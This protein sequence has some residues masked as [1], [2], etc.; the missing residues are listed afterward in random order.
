V[1]KAVRFHK[2]GGPENLVLEDVPLREPGAGEVKLSVQAIGLNRAELLYM[3]GFYFEKPSLPSRIGYEGA[4]IVEAV[5]PDVDPSLAGRSMSAIPGF[6]QNRYGLLAEE[7]IVPVEALREYPPNLSPAEAASI[8]MQYLTAWGALV[9]YAKVGRG[10]FVIIPAASSSVGLA[11]IQMT[12]L[13]GG[14]AIAATRT[15]KKREELLAF[16]ADYVIA[17]EEED[18]SRRVNEITDGKGSRVIFDPVGGPYVEKLA[19]VAAPGGIIIEYGGL[20][21]QPTPFPTR[22]A[23][24]KGLTMRGYSLMEFRN[25]RPVLDIGTKYVY[26]RLADGR[27]YPKIAK[28]FPFAQSAEAYR[29]LE[30]NQQIG[31]VV[32]TV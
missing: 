8:W 16:G 30:S 1:S 13:E 15:L 12:K 4:G 9:H 26:D 3:Q 21:M 25:N 5:G 28:T 10:D 14:I 2:L 11:A 32:I 27:L 23:I 31:K 29:Y 20:S 7:A 24:S 6:S 18:L 22:P 19:A 17:T